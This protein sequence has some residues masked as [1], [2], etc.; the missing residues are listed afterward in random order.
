MA[1]NQRKVNKLVD[2]IINWVLTYL[3]TP[4]FILKNP[5][6]GGDHSMDGMKVSMNKNLYIAISRL[7][8][9][10]KSEIS[11]ENISKESDISKNHIIREYKTLKMLEE[12]YS[13]INK[14]LN[15]RA[16]IQFQLISISF[17][18]ISIFTFSL[19]GKVE[20]VFILTF[21]LAPILVFYKFIYNFI[22]KNILFSHKILVND[23]KQTNEVLK[24]MYGVEKIDEDIW[25]KN[26]VLVEKMINI[27]NLGKHSQ[28][29]FLDIYNYL[30]YEGKTIYAQSFTLFSNDLVGTI[31]FSNF[32]N[33]YGVTYSSNL[34]EFVEG[35]FGDYPTIKNLDNP[36]PLED[37]VGVR[38]NSINALF[39]HL[40]HLLEIM[41]NSK[42]SQF[43]IENFGMTDGSAESRPFGD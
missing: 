6:A 25:D 18:I 35:E 13:Q 43:K 34:W 23:S 41:E 17:I 19:T 31:E 11:F 29:A 14:S 8:N 42:N 9:L 40:K 3:L 10:D 30:N 4:F 7:I 28:K 15:K 37:S 39:E 21:I 27:F 36:D 12:V 22:N 2:K 16:S 32:D 24:S 5:I 20:Y 33:N 38:L 1:S 26:T